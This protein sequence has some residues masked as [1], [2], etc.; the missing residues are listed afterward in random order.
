M[1]ANPDESYPPALL[2]VPA[3]FPPTPTPSSMTLLIPASL[4]PP[5]HTLLSHASV[6][7]PQVPHTWGSKLNPPGG[8]KDVLQMVYR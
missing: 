6:A 7:L 3:S 8:A 2:P 5:S 1:V 4:V